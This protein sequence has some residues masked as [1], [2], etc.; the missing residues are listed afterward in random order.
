MHVHRGPKKTGT[1]CC[2]NSPSV[3]ALL[4]SVLADL[5]SLKIDGFSALS[6]IWIKSY[7]LSLTEKS[8]LL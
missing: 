6:R 1:I 2:E 3:I 7:S 8:V 4:S 5:D